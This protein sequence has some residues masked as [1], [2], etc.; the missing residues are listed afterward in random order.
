MIVICSSGSEKMSPHARSAVLICLSSLLGYAESSLVVG[1]AGHGLKFQGQR[2]DVASLH[3]K[4]P[5][6]PVQ[7][8]SKAVTIEFWMKKIDKHVITLPFTLT[9]YDES[10]A[11][12]SI[13][14]TRQGF[15]YELGEYGVWKFSFA[16]TIFDCP[17]AN[18]T[19]GWSSEWHH[20]AVVYSAEE[21]AGYLK[22]YR[23]GIIVFDSSLLE[24][25][26]LNFSP[27]RFPGVLLLGQ[28]LRLPVPYLLN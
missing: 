17:R 25:P 26:V 22:A 11:P 21:D 16:S 5:S 9:A 23:N 8:A 20:I 19:F 7:A 15:M 14:D 1:A 3:L 10:D 27:V 28:V 2:A 4:Q 13:L 24:H 6:D 18:C 12:E